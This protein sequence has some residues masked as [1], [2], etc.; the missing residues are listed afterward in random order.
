MRNNFKKILYFC[1]L[2]VPICVMS[3]YVFYATASGTEGEVESGIIYMDLAQISGRFAGGQLELPEEFREELA[4]YQCIVQA[5]DQYVAENDIDDVFSC[6]L[7]EDLLYGSRAFD[8]TSWSIG[9]T[10]NYEYPL[11]DVDKTSFT[12]D[13]YKLKLEGREHTLYVDVNVQKG[14]VFLYPAE[15]SGVIFHYDTGNLTAYEKIVGME[16]GWPIEYYPD[17]YVEAD[18]DD[19]K[20]EDEHFAEV[21]L[22][23]LE[24][25]DFLK[26][27]EG[28]GESYDVGIYMDVASALKRY[29][30]ENRIEDFFYFDAGA[31]I[32]SQVTNMI[33]TCRVRSHNR[34]LYI[35]LDTVNMKC[36]VYPVEE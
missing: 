12:Q 35:D 24:H 29:V 32:I 33:F 2:I 31:D 30:E 3:T 21:S 14:K 17:F 13:S 25:L 23:E 4:L 34:T 5:V 8:V 9:R 10:G 1:M 26:F 7:Q 11:Q 18:W 20:Q 15:E 27:P 19:M 22:E 6:S 36:H 16:G 28:A